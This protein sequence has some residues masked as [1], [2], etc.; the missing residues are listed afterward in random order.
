MSAMA[1]RPRHPPYRRLI[2][3]VT[4]LMVV[5]CAASAAS[6][7]RSRRVDDLWLRHEAPDVLIAG[8]AAHPIYAVELNRGVLS[9]WKS[10]SREDFSDRPRGWH[11]FMLAAQ[12]WEIGGH[13]DRR[14]GGR[15]PSLWNQLGFSLVGG[16]RVW[17][18][19]IP[20]W[21]L[22]VVSGALPGVRFYRAAMARWREWR[23]ERRRRRNKGACAGCGYDLRATPQRCPE[24]GMV[25]AGKG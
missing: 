1:R 5:F 11:H 3:A 24:C 16:E 7:Y 9:F 17:A 10:R 4:A 12:P 20:C 21:L 22:V 13:F 23:L 14:N 25:V 2:N 6:W 18:M 15:S 19:T 8:E